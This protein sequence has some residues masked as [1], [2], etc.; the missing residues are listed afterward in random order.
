M[1][2][3]TCPTDHCHTPITVQPLPTVSVFVVVLPSIIHF[4]RSWKVTHTKSVQL[5]WLYY[6]LKNPPPHCSPLELFLDP[7]L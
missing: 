7:D 4:F 1:P 3:V 6:S 2:P 5:T